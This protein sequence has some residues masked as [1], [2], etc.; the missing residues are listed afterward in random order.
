MILFLTATYIPF[1]GLCSQLV[2]KRIYVNASVSVNKVL[3]NLHGWKQFSIQTETSIIYSVQICYSSM[4]CSWKWQDKKFN[5]GGEKS[6]VKTVL[7]FIKTAVIEL[8]TCVGQLCL[9]IF[10]FAYFLLVT[11][12]ISTQSYEWFPQ[13]ICNIIEYIQPIEILF[14]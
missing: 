4:Y 9:G 7:P 8:G 2:A 11:I 1:K 13:W 10:N 14:V 12:T 6:T 3:K 5:F